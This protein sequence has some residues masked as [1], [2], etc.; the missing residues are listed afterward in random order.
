[1]STD[2]TTM[3][4]VRLD[5]EYD[6]WEISVGNILQTEHNV[7]LAAATMPLGQEP[8]VT[9]NALPHTGLCMMKVI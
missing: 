4:R 5:P 3:C 1:M 8:P 2:S 9:S 6:L 7:G